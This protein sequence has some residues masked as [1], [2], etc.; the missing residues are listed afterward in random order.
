M[1]TCSGSLVPSPCGEEGALFSPS[2]LLRLLA[3]LYGAGP[4]LRAV[5][6]FGHST[7]AR[8]RLRLCFVPS[9]ARASLAARS[10][11]GALSLGVVCLL[12]SAAPASVS[13]VLV[14]CMHPVFSC[15]PPGGCRPSGVS[16][17]LWLET[18]GLF[19]VW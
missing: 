3:A 8:T 19:A 13:A 16:G 14:G 18:G 9:P 12:P 1:V 15:D 5:P 11:T 7:K 17:S 2:T 4:A 10:L 6:V